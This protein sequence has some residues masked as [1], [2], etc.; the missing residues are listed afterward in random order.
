[1]LI[2]LFVSVLNMSISAALAAVLLFVWRVA[3]RRVIPARFYYIL[4]L[5]LLFRLA[6]P[7]TMP[8]SLSLLNLF[9][10]S[11]KFSQGS[12]Y[13]VTMEYLTPQQFAQQNAE[14]TGR[15]PLQALAV[16]WFAVAVV[17]AAVWLIC[18][19]MV[20]RQ[21][22][23]AVL[24]RD[25]QV[26]QLHKTL[27]IHHRI[28][29]Y[30]SPHLLSPIVT[31]FWRPKVILPKTDADPNR[32][33][34]ALAHELVHAR[35]GDTAIKTL[36]FFA[37]ALHWYNPL[38]WL[39]FRQFCADM[40]TSCDEAVLGAFGIE[41]KKQYA[42]VLV[43]YAAA[44][45]RGPVAVLSVGFARSRV[46]R[47]IEKVLEYKRLPLWA[48]AVFAAVTVL[49]GLS[50]S[51]NPVLTENWQYTPKT[52]YV[53]SGARAEIQT[54]VQ[55]FVR[56]T[57]QGDA[58]A[59][60]GCS[61]A[62]AEYFAELYRPFAEGRLSLAVEHIFYTSPQSAEVFLKVRQNSGS[63]FP[64]GTERLVA[65]INTSAAMDGLYL[66]Q[67][68]PHERYNRIHAVD[69]SDEAVQIVENMIRFGLTSGENTPQNAP[70]IAAFCMAM[71]QRQSDA[72]TR[73]GIPA[74]AVEQA[75][76]DFFRIEDPAYLRSCD[77]YDAAQKVYH[78]DPGMGT[79]YE[80]RIIALEKSAAGAAVT[81]EFYKDPLQTQTEKI[82]K[83]TLER[84]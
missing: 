68:H 7:F 44:R 29:V 51:T 41:H 73:G 66:D 63:V 40:E 38:V 36:W 62:D 27:G 18:H 65:S 23:Y 80:Y 31:G 37:V 12:S 46:A 34:Y 49:I 69:Q 20:Q 26:S 10:S 35:R 25:Q 54:F 11:E 83:Y 59:I 48:A 45:P 39:A 75:A 81:V 84:A 21:L 53:N 56:M 71:A 17:L 33:Q 22:R 67:L 42:A 76:V 57:E 70:R 1:M 28:P 55:D 50:A 16:V 15:L 82:V 19:A 24:Y 8:S 72:P 52:V 6:I 58:A 9:P 74:Q 78:Y 79:S 5:V 13:M 14:Q 61:T 2:N 77:Y 47:R 30:T 64:Q 32:L 43:D 4:W 3:T 60:A